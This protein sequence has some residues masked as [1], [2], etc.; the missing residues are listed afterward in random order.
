MCRKFDLLI[1]LVDLTKMRI[2]TLVQIHLIYRHSNDE[3]TAVSSLFFSRLFIKIS[4]LRF[5]LN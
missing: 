1:Y 5:S 4:S 2:P 3:Y